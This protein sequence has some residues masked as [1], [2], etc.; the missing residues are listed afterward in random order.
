[1]RKSSLAQLEAF[2][3]VA[4]LGGFR[5]AAAQLHRT[6]PTI[7]LR[8]RELETALGVPLFDRNGSRVQM[9]GA[10]RE[11]MP[12]VE[13]ILSLSSEMEDRLRQSDPLHG[14]LRL[15]VNDTFALTCLPKT[16]TALER[17]YP[18]LR[19]DLHVD[20]STVLS[21]QLAARDLDLA[22]L[23]NPQMEEEEVSVQRLG[24]LDSAWVASPRLRLPSGT[25]TPRDLSEQRILINPSPSHMYMSVAHWFGTAG[26]EVRRT[27]T[28]N[29]I[30]IL[31]TLTIA[32]C[33]I[34][35]LPVAILQDEL[36]ADRLR[37]IATDPPVPP[38][39]MCAAYRE[40]T[41]G[42]SAVLG[43][44]ADFLRESGLLRPITDS[45]A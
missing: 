15:G 40:S 19:I 25:L 33:G 10:S 32:G 1:M 45:L 29:S 23:V 17:L 28:C 18:D 44:A 27:S 42:I 20:F 35:M 31:T 16:L 26:L 14:L 8:I 5:A 22:F 9:T 4:R 3:W 41:P 34:S 7:S 39:I 43:I 11:I 30:T 6:Q 2:Y 13:Q 24:Y 12:Y 21:D 38:M 37:L 36:A